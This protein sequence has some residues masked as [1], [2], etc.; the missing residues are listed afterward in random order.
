[1]T[2]V[3]AIAK[4]SKEQIREQ[5]KDLGRDLSSKVNEITHDVKTFVLRD[6]K[7]EST[8]SLKNFLNTLLSMGKK[9][10]TT[11]QETLYP[12]L[13]TLYQKYISGSNSKQSNTDTT[14]K[15]QVGSATQ[16][17]D[18]SSIKGY[19]QYVPLVL[20]LYFMMFHIFVVRVWILMNFACTAL[21]MYDNL[22]E[23]NVNQRVI[24][25]GFNELRKF[26][27]FVIGSGIVLMIFFTRSVGFFTLPLMI[28]L[29]NRTAKNI[30]NKG[31]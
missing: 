23:S 11:I 28:Y 22:T 15:T 21:Y 30:F 13:L 2:T 29:I 14:D 10:L 24:P 6:T 8:D 5:T 18:M 19:L 3:N 31:F 27:S 7:Q 16:N 17:I 25:I 12:Q 20:E 4:K 9:F 26:A 1:M